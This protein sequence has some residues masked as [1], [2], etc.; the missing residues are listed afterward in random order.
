MLQIILHFSLTNIQD[1]WRGR[2]D[3]FARTRGRSDKE[4]GRVGA[5]DRGLAGDQSSEFPVGGRIAN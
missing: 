1:Q 4:I 2:N 3:G 5:N